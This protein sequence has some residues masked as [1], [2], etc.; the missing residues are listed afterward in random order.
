MFNINISYNSIKLRNRY[1]IS[2]IHDRQFNNKPSKT[3]HIPDISKAKFENITDNG[4]WPKKEYHKGALLK[5]FLIYQIKCQI[6]D[7]KILSLINYFLYKG[8]LNYD[9]GITSIEQWI[10]NLSLNDKQQELLLKVV[11]IETK[12]IY[13][14][15]GIQHTP[16]KLHA[17][18][19]DIS[20]SYTKQKRTIHNNMKNKFKPKS[21]IMHHNDNVYNIAESFRDVQF[22]DYIKGT[23]LEL[24]K[25][26]S[27]DETNEILQLITG[28]IWGRFFSTHGF[29]YKYSEYYDFR[30][31]LYYGGSLSF[32][33][34]KHLRHHIMLDGK[35]Y[36]HEWDVSS[37][38]QVMIYGFNGAFP[39]AKALINSHLDL[40]TE[41]A[42]FLNKSLSQEHPLK[43]KIDRD[44]IKLWISPLVYG[45]NPL[46]GFKEHLMNN[47]IDGK[48]GVE[49]LSLAEIKELTELLKEMLSYLNPFRPFT[50]DVL[51]FYTNDFKEAFAYKYTDSKCIQ[52]YNEV[53]VKSIKVRLPNRK[54]KSLVKIIELDS[55]DKGK[56]ALAT[57]ANFTHSFDAALCRYVRSKDENILS[58]H[59]AWYH[60]DK[61]VIDNIPGWILEYL[62]MLVIIADMNPFREI[63]LSLQPNILISL[64]E[65]HLSSNLFYYICIENLINNQFTAEELQLIANRFFK[66]DDETFYSFKRKNQID[67][68]EL[69]TELNKEVDVSDRLTELYRHSGSYVLYNI[70]LLY[71]SSKVFNP[72]N[73][74]VIFIKIAGDTM[75]IFS[76]IPSKWKELTQFIYDRCGININIARMT[77][78]FSYP[79]IIMSGDNIKP[80]NIDFVTMEQLNNLISVY[81]KY[82]G[83]DIPYN[84]VFLSIKHDKINDIE[85]GL[86]IFD[87]LFDDVKIKDW[88]KGWKI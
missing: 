88:I 8:S 87:E 82:I 81:Y 59:D 1:T 41:A 20:Q 38:M 24:V 25:Q 85:N 71:G 46:R 22:K 14:M 23:N 9:E 69:H 4:K 55:V 7:Q 28:F 3:S 72:N 29:G 48:L 2:L 83:Y 18:S 52:H 68:E 11:N 60:F 34:N 45:S 49:S 75:L 17:T 56:T 62:S 73:H 47:Y 12:M 51:K 10:A 27:N 39:I 19:I 84:Y 54:R 42:E 32:T 61:E 79:G 86:H 33:N 21:T 78:N 76:K 70:W 44:L 66:F 50:I 57:L 74:V 40:H 16:L 64:M 37:S 53:E 80:L 58:V 63:L 77:K 26:D 35:K 15:L 5:A 6:A 30:G 65:K 31:R 36:E 43:G 13:H 67:S